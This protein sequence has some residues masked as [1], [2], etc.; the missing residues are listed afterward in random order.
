M[1]ITSQE[2]ESQ[3]S[4]WRLAAQA[5]TPSIDTDRAIQAPEVGQRV[6][7]VGCGTSWFIAQSYAALRESAGLGETDAFA[8]SE[9]GWGRAYDHIVAISR[10]GTTTEILRLLERWGDG[11]ATTAITAVADSPVSSLAAET[12]ALDFADEHSVVQT[13][14][15]TSA[16]AYLRATIGDP[17]ES[18]IAQA[19]EALAQPLPVQVDAFDHF[20]FL[21]HGWTNGLA[22]EAALKMREAAQAHT[23]SYPAMEYRHGPI[24]LA[25]RRSLVWVLGTPDDG[26]AD[27]VRA[28]GA[29]VLQAER[30]PMAELIMIQRAAVHL[31]EV[32]GLNPDSPRNLT[33]SVVLS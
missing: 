15:A 18:A 16:L 29:T 6:A 14:F 3:P 32:R 27:D 26:V 2:I 19:Q 12:V 23:E 13:R 1:S 33:R 5:G 11:A 7:V 21:G 24:S 20:V 9:F 25:G 8:A 22:S 17:L 28:T 30:D 10:S 4:C 31:A